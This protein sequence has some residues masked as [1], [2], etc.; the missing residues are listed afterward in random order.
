MLVGRHLGLQ[1]VL[2]I[3]V[4]GGIAHLLALTVLFR[5]PSSFVGNDVPT[6]I[7]S[8]V[9]RRGPDVRSWEAEV[10]CNKWP[11]VH[12]C[13]LAGA[14]RFDDVEEELHEVEWSSTYDRIDVHGNPSLQHEGLQ[15]SGKR[16][17]GKLTSRVLLHLLHGSHL[18]IWH[19]CVWVAHLTHSTA[20]WPCLRSLGLELARLGLDLHLI[21][22]LL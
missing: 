3:K 15:A 9:L 21:C 13:D 14:S 16:L 6:P 8:K 17:W 19:L 10:L 4:S 5:D 2:R 11:L 12:F 1:L 20:R 7:I 18:G 22:T